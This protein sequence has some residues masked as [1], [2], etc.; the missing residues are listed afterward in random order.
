MVLKVTIPAPA[1]KPEMIPAGEPSIKSEICFEYM[2]DMPFVTAKDFGNECT[3]IF[4]GDEIFLSVIR[5]LPATIL[6]SVGSIQRSLVLEGTILDTLSAMIILC[7][8]LG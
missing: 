4:T 6:H 3:V 7:R 2:G 8:L 1:G 5:S